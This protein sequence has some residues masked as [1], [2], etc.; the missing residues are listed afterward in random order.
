MSSDSERRRRE[1]ERRARI[2]R[3]IAAKKSQVSSLSS[4]K[5]ALQGEM[6]RMGG[7]VNEWNTSKNRF[8]GDELAK[9]VVV[10]D[11]F[12]GKASDSLSAKKEAMISTMDG[13]IAAT[14]SIKSGLSGQI[15]R[16]QAKID[17]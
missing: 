12:E 14:A 16:I 4:K 11:V 3:E 13:K 6:N 9:R 2:H 8:N 10:K 15:S 1:A 5:S 7:Y 17:S